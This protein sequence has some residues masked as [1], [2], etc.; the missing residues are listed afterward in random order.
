MNDESIGGW[1]DELASSTPAP[2][3]GAAAALETAIAAALIEMYCNL[4]IGKPAYAEHDATTTSVRDRAAEI[5]TEALTLAAE[6][7]AAFAAVIDAYRLP[8]GSEGEAQRRRER[9]QGALAGAADVP[10]RTA[11]AATEILDLAETVVPLG[12]VNVVSDAAAAAAAARAALQT[13]LLNIDANRAL[14]D[15]LVLGAELATVAA[16]LEQQLARADRI[17]AAVRV[18]AA[19]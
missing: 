16:E 19:G 5:R 12:N 11:A 8:K 7:A 18:R 1:L 13:A 17:V 6:D 9:I 15:D 3:G 10:R 4:T 2:G 14:I